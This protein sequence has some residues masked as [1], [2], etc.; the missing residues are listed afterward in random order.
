[1]TSDSCMIRVQPDMKAYCKLLASCQICS[2]IICHVLQHNSYLNK[3]FVLNAFH[4]F[5]LFMHLQFGSPQTYPSSCSCSYPFLL[6]VIIYYIKGFGSTSGSIRDEESWYYY[7]SAQT[8]WNVWHS[9]IKYGNTSKL[10]PLVI[11]MG[12][13]GHIWIMSNG[14]TWQTIL[15]VDV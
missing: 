14:P 8:T 9:G 2:C 15:I 10:S 11:V 3:I 12:W 13:Y 4:I 7:V 6:P 1:M 5:V